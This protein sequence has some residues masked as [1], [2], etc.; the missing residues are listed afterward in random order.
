MFSPTNSHHSHLRAF[1]CL[2]LAYNSAHNH[3]KLNP[4]GVPCVFLGYPVFQKG[5]K[6]FNLLIKQTFISRD[7]KW[8]ENVFTYTLP[9][10]QLQHL[11]PSSPEHTIQQPTMWEDSSNDETHTNEPPPEPSSPPNPD[12]QPTS[13]AP[14][15]SSLPLRCSERTKST[16]AWLDDYVTLIS[17]S[18]TTFVTPNFQCFMVQ[19]HHTSDPATFVEASNNL[20]GSWL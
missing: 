20:T 4:R 18:I 8:C 16:P 13:F 6:L 9:S 3:D 1:G 17:N 14:L 12:T 19:V 15:P 2:A 5:Y 10:T 11:I 7:I